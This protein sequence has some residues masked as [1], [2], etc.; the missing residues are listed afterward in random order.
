MPVRAEI[1]GQREKEL[2]RITSEAYI[3]TQEI[4]GKADSESIGIYGAAYSQDPAFYS[5][6]AT[7]E[8]YPEPLKNSRLVL[9]TDSEFLKYLKDSEK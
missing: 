1:N 8:R 6:L 7:L 3:K 9:T 5:F 2:K 4:R